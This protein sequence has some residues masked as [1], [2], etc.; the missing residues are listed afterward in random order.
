MSPGR[1]IPSLRIRTFRRTEPKLAWVASLNA[2]SGLLVAE[3]INSCAF[4]SF[5][6]LGLCVLPNG[7]ME[8]C[9]GHIEDM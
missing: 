4:W 1:G 7:N 8:P 2:P 6:F 9:T 5:W 3:V